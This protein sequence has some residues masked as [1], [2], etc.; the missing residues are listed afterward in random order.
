MLCYTP[1]RKCPQVS[2]ETSGFVSENKAGHFQMSR[3]K[4]LVLLPQTRL[5]NVQRSLKYT[6]WRCWNAVLNCGHWL[7]C[8]F[9]PNCHPCPPQNIKEAFRSEQ[10]SGLHQH[11]L[12]TFPRGTGLSWSAFWVLAQCFTNSKLLLLFLFFLN[13]SSGATKPVTS[14]RSSIADGV[15]NSEK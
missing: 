12:P 3:Q 2:S 10:T 6:T 14:E 5:E 11:E 9:S 15:G 4:C 8:F 7:G 1:G 13:Y